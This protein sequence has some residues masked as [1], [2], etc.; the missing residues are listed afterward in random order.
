MK[1]LKR[2]WCKLFG[3]NFENRMYLKVCKRCNTE[4]S[5]DYSYHCGFHGG[6]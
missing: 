1:Y 4:F 6:Q 2:L 3:H 5:D